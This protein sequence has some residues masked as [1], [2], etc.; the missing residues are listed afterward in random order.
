MVA[1][2]S[3]HRERPQPDAG[4]A[5]VGRVDRGGSL[6]REL[7]DAVERARSDIAVTVVDRS[8]ACVRDRGL[9]PEPLRR[10]EDVDR[11]G[12]VDLRAEHRVLANERHLQR[13]E[14]DDVGDLVLG[15]DPLDGLELGEVAADELHRVEFVRRP[16]QAKSAE[17]VAEVECDH[18]GS[19]ADECERR[20]RPDAAERA[21]DE[22]ALV[23]RPCPMGTRPRDC[24]WDMSFG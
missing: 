11:S 4:N 6:V 15:E 1:A 20:P 10:L 14:V 22:P 18:V 2:G 12:H 17:V 5:V 24:P 19:L 21:G 23:H 3:V 9:E 7:E 16:D 8:R 13:G